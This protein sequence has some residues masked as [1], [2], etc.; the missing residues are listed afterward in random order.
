MLQPGPGAPVR[1]KMILDESRTVQIPIFRCFLSFAVV[2]ETWNQMDFKIQ[3]HG[4]NWLG[5]KARTDFST[6]LHH[7]PPG[8]AAEPADT[9][10]ASPRPQGWRPPAGWWKT[11][12]VG[13][14]KR[15][16]RS[17]P[18]WVQWRFYRKMDSLLQIMHGYQRILP[19]M[20][21]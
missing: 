15:A 5:R 7:L 16:P 21:L 18:T 2:V 11:V 20:I 8:R 19:I 3:I 17:D 1:S 4:T 10:R 9:R 12:G 6:S 14:E 13:W